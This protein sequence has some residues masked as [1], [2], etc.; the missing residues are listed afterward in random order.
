MA[1]RPERFNWYDLAVVDDGYTIVIDASP[2]IYLA[3]LDALDV[4]AASQRAGIVPPT[5]HREVANPTLTYAHPDALLLE[6]AFRRGAI[7][8]TPLTVA[9]SALAGRFAVEV[10]GMHSGEREVLA[11]ARQ[12]RVPAVLF[13]RRARR[14]AGALGVELVDAVELLFDGTPGQEV[15]EQRVRR[16]AEMVDMRLADYEALRERVHRRRPK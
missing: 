5:V 2:L 14:V 11:V 13:E 15:L 4:F 16:F 1:P 6:E 7:S 9:E 3:K 12:R 10:P 8:V